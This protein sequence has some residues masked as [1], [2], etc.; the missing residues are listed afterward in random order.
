MK[1]QKRK[2]NIRKKINIILNAIEYAQK[3]NK[4][5]SKKIKIIAATKKQPIEK[6]KHVENNQ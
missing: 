4:K 2:N 6:K 1:T 5:A 3:K